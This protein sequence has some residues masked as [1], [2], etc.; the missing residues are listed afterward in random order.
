MLKKILTSLWILSTFLTPF[1]CDQKSENSPIPQGEPLLS[2]I[3][4][5]L[6]GV[7]RGKEIYRRYGC[8]LCHGREGE[9]GIRNINTQTADL[10]PH[11]TYVAEGYTKDELKEKIRKGVWDIPRESPEGPTPPYRMPN[12]GLEMSDEDL[13]ALVSYLMSLM[14]EKEEEEW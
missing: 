14:P 3:D 8:H 9:K 2:P 6:S 1:G 11:L 5:N 12:I 13:D 10:I 4:P 7:E